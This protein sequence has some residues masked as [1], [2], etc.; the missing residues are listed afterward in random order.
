MKL[1]DLERIDSHMFTALDSKEELGVVGGQSTNGPTTI[2]TY[3]PTGP[4][5]ILDFRIDPNF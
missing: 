4:D 5:L 1:N 3:R 2:H